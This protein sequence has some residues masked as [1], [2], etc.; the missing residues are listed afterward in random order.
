[1]HAS[2]NCRP[3]CDGRCEF[4]STVEILSDYTYCSSSTKT[5]VGFFIA[6]L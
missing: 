6:L 1:M 5:I 2:V 3:T 4:L